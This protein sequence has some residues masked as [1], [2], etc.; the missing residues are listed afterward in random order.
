VYTTSSAEIVSPVS[1]V[2]EAPI[3]GVSVPLSSVPKARSVDPVEPKLYVSPALLLPVPAVYLPSLLALE[4]D[5][6]SA[7]PAGRTSDW[8]L[9]ASVSK[10]CV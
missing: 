5:S 2:N 8:P 7:Q 4:P 10:S 6:A 3:V 1:F 9:A